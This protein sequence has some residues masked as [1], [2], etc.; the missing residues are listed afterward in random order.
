M[1]SPGLVRILYIEDEPDIQ[2]I[3]RLALVAVG[4][5]TVEICSSGQEA[6]QMV[7]SFHPDLILLDVMMPEMDGPATLKALRTLPETTRTPV[8]FMTAKVQSHEVLQY[9]EMG[10]IDVI[11]K[12]FDPMTLSSTI[13]S[14]WASYHDH[15]S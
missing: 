14:I 15:S 9:K 5:F 3:A 1:S 13:C 12:P 11:S 6:L 8:I 10:A 2:A 7:T 4:G